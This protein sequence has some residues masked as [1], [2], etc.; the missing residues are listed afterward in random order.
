MLNVAD[1]LVDMLLHYKPC[2]L[3]VPLLNGTKNIFTIFDYIS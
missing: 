1:Y 3:C 2:R